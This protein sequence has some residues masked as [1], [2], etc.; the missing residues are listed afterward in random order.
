MSLV[1]VFILKSTLSDVRIGM[2]AFF[3]FPFAWNIFSISSFSVCMCRS[4]MTNT[5]RD[6]F[7]RDH[8]PR[9][10]VGLLQTAYIRVL[11]LY[12]FSQSMAFGWSI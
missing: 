9:S 10:E 4:E 2:P 7:P 5:Y 6:H 12:P 8:F 11:V 1:I 3:S